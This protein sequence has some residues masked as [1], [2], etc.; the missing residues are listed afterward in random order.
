M[1][2]LIAGSEAGFVE[3]MNELAAKLGMTNTHYVNCTGLP[4]AGAYSCAADV[5]KIYSYIM[6]S[7]YYAQSGNNIWM[8]DFTHP[9]GRVTGLT[10]TNKHARFFPDCT[11]GKTGFTAE[12]GHCITVTAA[13]KNLQPI[14]VIIGASD[15]KTRFA[16]SARL[17][18][19][20]FDAYENKLIVDSSKPIRVGLRNAVATEVDLFAERDFY[21]LCKKGEKIEHVVNIELAKNVK[22]PLAAGEVHGKV[23]VTEEGKVIAEIDIVSKTEVDNLN[24][25]DAIK[26]VIGKYKF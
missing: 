21:E 26:K 15:S 2:E 1:A 22:A 5:A 18:N 3:K 16:E 11:G 10:N 7:P 17:M 19:H 8:Y 20:T 12:A 14:A 24:Y 6:K 9:S 25:F 4:A 23:L 13:R